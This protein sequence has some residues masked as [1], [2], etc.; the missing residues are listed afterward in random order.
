MRMPQRLMDHP[1]EAAVAGL[2]LLA[3]LFGSADFSSGPPQKPPARTA[4]KM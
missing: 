2:L 4:E 1:V 3:L